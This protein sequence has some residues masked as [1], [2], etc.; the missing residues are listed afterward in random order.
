MVWVCCCLSGR[1]K[2][3]W[4]C[5]GVSFSNIKRRT[6]FWTRGRVLTWK[7]LNFQCVENAIVR[8]FYFFSISWCPFS[9]PLGGGPAW[10]AT[11]WARKR[12]PKSAGRFVSHCFCIHRVRLFRLGFFLF[13]IVLQRRLILL[14]MHFSHLG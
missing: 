6:R 12:A 4:F 8:P 2:L 7:F 1:C 10:A 9:C 13:V 5:F 3:E 11:Q 14:C